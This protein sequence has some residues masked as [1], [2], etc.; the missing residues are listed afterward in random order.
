MAKTSDIARFN[1]K[2]KF[3]VRHKNICQICGRSRGYMGRFGICRLCFRE[4]A[5]KGVLPGVA[6]ASW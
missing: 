4:L 1:K 2:Q 3:K 5:H 6:K